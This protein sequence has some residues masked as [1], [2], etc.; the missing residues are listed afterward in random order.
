MT[1]EDLRIR[2]NQHRMILRSKNRIS[3]EHVRMYFQTKDGD[4]VSIKSTELLYEDNKAII[5]LN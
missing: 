4:L 3:D 2:L 1:L 5:V